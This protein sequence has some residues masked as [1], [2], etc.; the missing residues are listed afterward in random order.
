MFHSHSFTSVRHNIFEAVVRFAKLSSGSLS[1]I[2]DSLQFLNTTRKMCLVSCVMPALMSVPSSMLPWSFPPVLSRWAGSSILKSSPT[3]SL[4]CILDAW[5]FK[6]S[7]N[8]KLQ[9][10][11]FRIPTLCGKFIQCNHEVEGPH[12]TNQ[13]QAQKISWVCAPRVNGDP[14]HPFLVL[15]TRKI[16]HHKIRAVFYVDRGNSA[17][18]IKFMI[19]WSLRCLLSALLCK[20]WKQFGQ[21][22]CLGWRCSSWWH[23]N[24]N[25]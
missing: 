14:S 19:K 7:E 15:V 2:A 3:I 11:G 6:W 23:L 24:R 1:C 4:S 9:S 8:I 17:Q 5:K 25:S 12:A 21:P 16:I 18:G 10:D 22:P 20:R 13:E